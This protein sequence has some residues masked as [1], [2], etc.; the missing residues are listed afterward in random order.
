M[1]LS[2]IN[3]PPADPPKRR[4]TRSN[5]KLNNATT[6]ATKVIATKKKAPINKAAPKKKKQ[7]IKVNRRTSTTHSTLSYSPS[8]SRTITTDF[9][10]KRAPPKVQR[11]PPPKTLKSITIQ[12]KLSKKDE[13]LQSSVKSDYN[14]RDKGK[15][16]LYVIV[17]VV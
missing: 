8:S 11:K 4:T 1:D 14:A 9:G 5:S 6:N 16:L 15:F 10:I 2:T 7:Q 12:S 3:A 17:V 13:L